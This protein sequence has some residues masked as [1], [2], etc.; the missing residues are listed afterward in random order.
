M[1]RAVRRICAVSGAA[2][3]A[4]CGSAGTNDYGS[5]FQLMSQGWRQ[6]VGHSRVTLQ[7]AA[8]KLTERL[9]PKLVVK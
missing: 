8:A 1:K 5:F 3:L 4:G 9:L 6:S 7:E 2:V